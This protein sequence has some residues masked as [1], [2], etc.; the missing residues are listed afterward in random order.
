MSKDASVDAQ[1]W[2]PR[3][4]T[5]CTI[6]SI[7]NLCKATSVRDSCPRAMHDDGNSSQRLQTSFESLHDTQHVQAI[8]KLLCAASSWFELA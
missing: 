7:D 3:L 4:N 5:A 2:Q 8:G 1:V 6:L